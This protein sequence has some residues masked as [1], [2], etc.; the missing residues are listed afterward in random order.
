MDDSNSICFLYKRSLWICKYAGIFI[1]KNTDSQVI[2]IIFGFVIVLIGFEMY[3]RESKAKVVKE[4]KIV[5]VM[6]GL[7]SGMLCGLYGIGALLAAYVIV[8]MGIISVDI[9]KDAIILIPFMLIG[10]F[11]GMKSSAVLNE[12]I[13]KKVVILMLIL[14]GIGL[15]VNNL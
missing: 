6:I 1:L 14:S 4:S 10:L 12:K 11:V 15:I 2:K 9:F 8:L 3:F 5:L 7:I 13:V